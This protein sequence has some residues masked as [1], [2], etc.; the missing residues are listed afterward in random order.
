[1]DAKS[2]IIGFTHSA[3]FWIIYLIFISNIKNGV[4]Q[5]KSDCSFSGILQVF[6]VLDNIPSIDVNFLYICTLIKGSV[7]PHA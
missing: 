7:Y 4:L 5:V 6:S 3:S 2:A 1:M